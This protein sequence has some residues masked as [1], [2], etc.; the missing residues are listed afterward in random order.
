KGADPVLGVEMRSTGEVA[1]I[2]YDFINTFVRAWIS[3]G[4]SL[5]SRNSIIFI[6]VRD[7]DKPGAAELAKKLV[8][9][10]FTIAATRGTK[11]FLS[12]RGL[13]N[14]ILVNRLSERIE[15]GVDSMS[16]LTSGGIG[17]VINTPD[18]RDKETLRDMYVIRRTAVEFAIPVVTS[19]EVAE[20]II[21]AMR[22]KNNNH[23][24]A[25][26]PCSLDEFH[27]D[28]PLSKYV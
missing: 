26:M 18:L 2:G 15:G 23:E 10:G 9:M 17:L 6:T 7:E 28:I 3:S 11:S 21:E 25:Y 22:F 19:L 1:C 5:P 12:S 4:L 13:V 8:E 14:V 16:F 20:R 27:K 24:S